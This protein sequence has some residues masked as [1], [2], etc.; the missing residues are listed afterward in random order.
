MSKRE[1]ECS[2]ENVCKREREKKRDVG[3]R[4]REMKEG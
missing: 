4:E 3:E 1:R 2:I